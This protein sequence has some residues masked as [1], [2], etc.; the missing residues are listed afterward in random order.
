MHADF[1]KSYVWEILNLTIRKM[2]QHVHKLTVESSEARARLHQDS[3]DSD[4][5]GERR[6]AHRADRPSDEQVERMEE[7]LEQAQSDQKTLFLIIFQRFI[8]ILSEHLVRSDTDGKDFRTHWWKWTFGRLQ[9]I[10]MQH[11]EQ[12]HKY[13]QTLETLLFTQDLDPHVLDAFHQ[14]LALRA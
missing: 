7:R 10:F 11:N 6:A 5:E 14:F 8:M 4:S 13:S 12:V 9:Q 2:S 3:E 1:L